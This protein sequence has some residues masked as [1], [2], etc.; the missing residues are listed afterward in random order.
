[1]FFRDSENIV[2]L[3]TMVATWLSPVLYTWHMVPA[4]LGQTVFDLYMLNPITVAVELFHFAFWMPTTDG[5]VPSPDN[6][7]SV[8][9]PVALVVSAGLVLVGNLVFRRLEGRFAQ[10]L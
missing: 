3:L 9:T 8:W 4:E 2:D 6:L 7:F 5:T 10:E 1:V